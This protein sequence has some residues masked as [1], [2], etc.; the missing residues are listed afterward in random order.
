[1]ASTTSW[2]QSSACGPN[3]DAVTFNF[4]AASSTS[5]TGSSRT[6]TASAT[7]ATFGV[8][9]PGTLR[10]NTINFSISITGAVWVTGFPALNQ[11]GGVPNSLDLNMDSG[12]PGDSVNMLMTFNRPMSKVRFNMYDVDRQNGSW[13]DVLRISGSLNGATVPIPV[14]VPTTPGNYSTATIAGGNQITTNVSSNCASTIGNCN[15][16][17]NFDNPVNQ[18]SVLF[19]AGPAVASPTSQ[20]VGFNDFSYCVIKRDLSLSK[21]GVAPTFVAGQSGSYTLTVTNRGGAATTG[22]VTVSD[23][24][25][26]SSVSFVSPQVPGGGWV[27]SLSATSHA[28]DTA[29]CVRSAS[30][31]AGSSAQLPLTVTV[32]PDAN[33]ASFDNRAKVFGG[34]DDF[35]PTLTTTGPIADC[36]SLNEGTSGGGSGSNAGCAFE[37]TLLVRQGALSINKT[38]VLNTLTAGQ[39]T[40]YTIN[41][42]NAGPSSANSAILTDPVA[43]GLIC[44]SVTCSAASGGAACPPSGSVTISALQNSGIALPVFPPNSSLEFQVT[45]TVSATGVP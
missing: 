37:N 22:N 9:T 12:A 10:S 8:A 20:R 15:V 38:N 31:G 14:L 29:T 24:L 11:Q 3:E 13:Q 30:I 2:A 19:L 18:I 40:T 28:N 4:A 1:M 43:G 33:S 39:T 6:W 5:A 25:T 36:S 35:K 41:A 17:I 26:D 34:G 21:V 7:S 16:Q 45:C 44:T 23:I 42:T 32:S 27:C